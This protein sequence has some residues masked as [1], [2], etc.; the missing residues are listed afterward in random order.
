MRFKTGGKQQTV[1]FQYFLCCKSE[2]QTVLFH[3]QT[4]HLVGMSL[5]AFSHQGALKLP[6]DIGR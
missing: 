5:K 3:I 2:L 1:D 6:A 4:F